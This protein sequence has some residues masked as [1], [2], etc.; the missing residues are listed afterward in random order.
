L[1]HHH[2]SHDKNSQQSTII[3]ET[4]E[5]QALVMEGARAQ[6]KLGATFNIGGLHEVNAGT[7]TVEAIGYLY[8]D[9]YH[10]T[11][12]LK[13]LSYEEGGGWLSELVCETLQEA[14]IRTED[15][16]DKVIRDIKLISN[17]P[18]EGWRGCREGFVQEHF[19]PLV[20]LLLS[21]Y[22]VEK[23]FP[24]RRLPRVQINPPTDLQP[25]TEEI[26]GNDN[27][28]EETQNDNIEERSRDLDMPSLF[29]SYFRSTPGGISTNIFA[30][31]DP[32]S[33]PKSP[34]YSTP[35]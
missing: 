16:E 25:T 29:G 4:E 22:N 15:L 12:P 32:W 23:Y 2:K 8:P 10:V 26:S 20:R 11:K 14:L 31:Q 7:A 34:N 19:Q 24:L 33:T 5:F 1:E 13:M 30:P 28:E 6:R 27:I 21:V 17:M 35:P 9:P 3:N 18:I